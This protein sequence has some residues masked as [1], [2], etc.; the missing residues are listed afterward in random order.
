MQAWKKTRPGKVVPNKPLTLAS[1][2]IIFV[3]PFNTLEIRNDLSTLP[4][5]PGCDNL[6]EK[7]H[8]QVLALGKCWHKNCFR[9]QKCRAEFPDSK[10]FIWYISNC[11]VAQ[12]I[13]SR[14]NMPY[15]A[16]CEYQLRSAEFPKCSTCYQ[17]ISDASFVIAEVKKY[18]T[19][20]FLKFSRV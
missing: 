19:I 20:C 2:Y 13:C 14:K 9:C 1:F 18:C 10:F 6:L 11:Y 15:C 12:F 5:C 4:R 3:N 7:T 17:P 16:S 8:A